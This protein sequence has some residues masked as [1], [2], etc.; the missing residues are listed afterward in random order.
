MICIPINTR[1]GPRRARILALR[2]RHARRPRLARL[3][4]ALCTGRAH[5]CTLTA[6]ILA[7]SAIGARWT[8]RG[9]EGAR[10]AWRGRA[11]GG[12]RGGGGRTR[13]TRTLARQGLISPNS[14][15]C[16]RRRAT[17]LWKKNDTKI[18]VHTKGAK[19]TWNR[20]RQRQRETM[21]EC[22]LYRLSICQRHNLSQ[23]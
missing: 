2:A 10:R 3:I 23:P 19:S 18:F 8:A 22:T 9:R 1:G 14:T 15:V 21:Y 5:S 12:P 20:I 16:A 4:R 7:R 6:G 13:G 11:R 17:C